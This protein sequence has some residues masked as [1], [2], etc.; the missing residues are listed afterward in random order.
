MKPIVKIISALTLVSALG[1]G[2]ALATGAI[3]LPS[4]VRSA[5][6]RVPEGTETQTDFARHA[7]IDR[8]QAEAAA[9]AAV[10]GVAVRA[11]LD[12]EDGYLVWQVDVSTTRGLMEVMVDAGNGKVLAA[13]AEEDDDGDHV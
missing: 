3:Q 2:A 11:K 8:A 6:I 1:A 4:E 9:L 10:P 7:R 5:S 12:D 13:E